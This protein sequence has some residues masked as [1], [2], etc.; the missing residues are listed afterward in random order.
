MD[1]SRDYVNQDITIVDKSANIS[2]ANISQ[3]R[4]R[5]FNES[6]MGLEEGGLQVMTP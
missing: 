5:K 6:R 1:I 2:Q 3:G 4:A